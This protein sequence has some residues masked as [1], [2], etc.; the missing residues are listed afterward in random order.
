MNIQR[1]TFADDKELDNKLDDQEIVDYTFKDK[2][3]NEKVN[4]Q[5]T[6]ETAK[7][8]ENSR[9][10]M[11]RSQNAYNHRVASWDTVFNED[12]PENEHYLIDPA[13]DVDSVLDAMEGDLRKAAIREQRRALVE[14]ALH[15]LTPLQ[16]E[17][18]DLIFYENK[19]E[20][21]I[22][23]ILGISHQ[24][25]HRRRDKAIKNLKNY[26]FDTQN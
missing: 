20:R 9:K 23:K 16:R 3:H 12:K 15:C 26:I 10:Q 11:R 1:E 7:Y 14:N 8:L 24:T 21:E 25:V 22:S 6:R 18:I 5:I 2:I 17:V 19:S 13:S 4:V